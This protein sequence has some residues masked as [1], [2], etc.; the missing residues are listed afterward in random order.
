MSLTDLQAKWRALHDKTR[1]LTHGLE[2]KYGS[3]WYIYVPRSQRERIEAAQ[4]R[5]DKAREAIFAW[6]EQ[7]SPRS[8]SSG[9]PCY[10]VCDSLTEADALTSGQLTVTPPPGYG[11]YPSDMIRFAWPVKPQ[12]VFSW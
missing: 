3:P 10:W 12:E 5:E 8:W 7:H 4:R 9:V 11:S 2:R 1:E 6:L